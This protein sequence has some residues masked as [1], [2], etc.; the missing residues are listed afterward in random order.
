MNSS[1]A[2]FQVLSDQILTS[3]KFSRDLLYE[4]IA[5][6]VKN[7]WLS[8]VQ[9]TFNCRIE[10][11]VTVC[12]WLKLIVE[13]VSPLSVTTTN[14][15]L[16]PPLLLLINTHTYSIINRVLVNNA[17]FTLSL[18]TYTVLHVQVRKVTQIKNGRRKYA[19]FGRYLQ[20]SH[21]SKVNR[22]VV[23]VDITI[24]CLY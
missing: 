14:Q 21:E 20:I 23:L 24:D 17:M 10:K 7:A 11:K 5:R 9:R 18:Y 15:I 1:C 12:Y 13:L 4:L 3:S 6:R 19:I 2:F 22:L 16:F 8:L